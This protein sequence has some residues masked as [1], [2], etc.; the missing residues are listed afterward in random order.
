MS[1]GV[2]T[3]VSHEEP[4]LTDEALVLACARRD[5]AAL[6]L[7]FERYS[8][9]VYRFISR[10][11]GPDPDE[12][13]DL[14]QSVFIELWR[15][16]HKYQRRSSARVWIFGIA[17]N[18]ARTALRGRRR[19]EA[20]VDRFASMPLRAV[21]GPDDALGDRELVRRLAAALEDLSEGQRGAFVLCE[22]EELTTQEAALVLDARPGTVGRWVVEAR[23][24]LREHL[25]DLR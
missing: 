1:G 13:D 4:A 11:V 21:P 17:H 7:L 15:V 16:A 22:L 6:A 18:V 3:L 5:E 23:R 19:R 10:L 14:A 9:K 8:P 24:R 12:V 25:E 20:A 2:L